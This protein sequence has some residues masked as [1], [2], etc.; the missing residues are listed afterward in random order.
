MQFIE[1][2]ICEFTKLIWSSTLGLE[3]E[4]TDSPFKQEGKE[5]NLAGCVQITGTWNGTVALHC[6]TKLAEQAAAI[7]FNLDNGSV[8]TEEVQDALGEL[9]NMTSGNIK[10]LLPE[11]NYLSLPAVAVTDHN[12]RIPGSE[13]VT[14]ITFKCNGHL[15]TVT[16][17]R[18]DERKNPGD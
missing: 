15:F 1:S 4:K 8:T 6:P 12:L 16:L 9:S 2:E 3:V 11:P 7:M 14:N 5:K 10:S 13:V 18:K 17:L